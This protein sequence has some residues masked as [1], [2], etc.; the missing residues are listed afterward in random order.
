[1]YGSYMY[2]LIKYLY[3]EKRKKNMIGCPL[4]S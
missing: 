3:F 2:K 4:Y 1:M